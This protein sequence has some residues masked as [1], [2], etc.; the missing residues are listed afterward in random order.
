MK[1]EIIGW[2]A[3]HAEW[4]A[5]GRLLEARDSFLQWVEQNSQL[6]KKAAGPQTDA[7]RFAVDSL[8]ERKRRPVLLALLECLLKSDANVMAFHSLEG[9]DVLLPLL[10]QDDDETVVGVLRALRAAARNSMF[11]SARA[12]LT[13]FS[14]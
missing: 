8:R 4:L 2:L 6:V 7:V 3:R 14:Y 11:L 10:R 1:L 13:F 9:M 12:F 5:A